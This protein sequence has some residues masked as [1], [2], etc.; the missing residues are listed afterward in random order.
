M[1][2]F[3]YH[4]PVNLISIKTNKN[5]KYKMKL[6]SFTKRALPLLFQCP[7]VKRKNCSLLSQLFLANAFSLLLHVIAANA[8]IP[9][10]SSASG[11]MALEQCSPN[12]FV[13]AAVANLPIDNSTTTPNEVL[14]LFSHGQPGLL[15]LEGKWQ[16]A[17]QIANWLTS[18]NLLANKQHINIYACEFAQGQKG[19]DAV[20]YLESTLGVSVAASTNMTGRNGDWTLEVGQPIA[21][22]ALPNYEG[23]LQNLITNGSFS[24]SANSWLLSGASYIGWS[25]HDQ[26]MNLN[27]GNSNYN[28]YGQQTINTIVGNSY[29]ITFTAHNHKTESYGSDWNQSLVLTLGSYSETISLQAQGSNHGSV[30]YS[31]TFTATSTAT[32]IKFAHGGTNSVEHD[33]LIDDVS[34]PYVAPPTPP[35]NAGNVAPSLSSSV[36]SNTCPTTTVN[37]NSMVIGSTTNIRWFNNNTHTGTAYA[38]PTAAVGGTYYAFYYDA[39]NNCYSP[40]SL[41]L[42]VNTITCGVGPNPD[43]N[44]CAPVEYITNSN[45]ECRATPNVCPNFNNGATPTAHACGWSDA[46][47]YDPL[48]MTYDYDNGCIYNKPSPTWDNSAAITSGHSGSSWFGIANTS[49]PQYAQMLVNKLTDTLAVGTY[50]VKFWAGYL[51]I[52]TAPPGSSVYTAPWN[53]DSLTIYGFPLEG[54]AG[55]GD[56]GVIGYTPTIYGH[57]VGVSP[58]ISN[59]ISSGNQTWVEYS[60]TITTTYPINKIGFIHFRQYSYIYIDDVSL[61]GPDNKCCVSPDKKSAYCDYDGDGIV[62]IKDLD[63]D[64]DGI[65]DATE[66]ANT[67]YTAEET[68]SAG[69]TYATTLASVPTTE[70]NVGG[71]GT[72]PY[73]VFDG[74]EFGYMFA[75]NEAN[76]MGKQVL[77]WK[78]N[79]VLPLTGIKVYTN[80]PYSSSDG[81]AKLQGSSDGVTWVNLSAPTSMAAT[82][83][84]TDPLVRVFDILNTLQPNNAY[85]YYRIV[86]VTGTHIVSSSIYEVKPIINAA[87]FNPS[88]NP[89]TGNWDVYQYNIPSASHGSLVPFT[90][91]GATTVTSKVEQ[92]IASG[93]TFMYNGKP[94]SKVASNIA[95]SSSGGISVTVQAT[96]SPWTDYAL[97]DA[98][99]ITNG[100]STFVLDNSSPTGFTKSG[101]W[102]TVAAASAYNGSYE[103]VIQVGSNTATWTFSNLPAFTLCNTDGDGLANIFDLDSDGDGCADAAEGAANITTTTNSTLDGGNFGTTYTGTSTNPVTQN[104]GNTVGTAYNTLGVP[105]LA[106]TGQAVGTSQNGT[107]LDTNCNNLTIADITVNESAGTATVQICATNIS[108]TPIT[109]TYTTSNGTATAGS[110]YTATTGTATIAAGQTCTSIDVPITDDNLGEPTE[111]INI[112]LTNPN[113]ATVTDPTAV[114]SITDN[115]APTLSVTDVVVNENAGTATVQICASN[116]STVPMTVT[117]TTANGTATSGTDYTA[118]TATATIAIGQTCTVVTVPIIDDTNSESPETFT[119]NLTNPSGATITDATGVITINDNDALPVLTINNVAVNEN[120]GIATL[121][122]CS[123]IATT[124]PMTV[125]YTTGNASATSGS[126]YTPKSAT[127]TIPAGQTCVNVTVSLIDDFINEPTETFNVT[128]TNPTGATIGDDTGVVTILDNDLAATPSLT[129][130]DVTV[131]EGVNPTATLQIC[132]SSTSTSPMTVTYTTSNGSA[133]SGSDYTTTTGTATIPAGQTCVDVTVPILDNT[134]NEPT[135][136]FNVILSNPS[137]ATLNDPVGVVTINDNDSAATPT[138]SINDVTVTEGVNPTATLQICASSTSTSPMTVTYTTNNGSATSGSDYSA[139]TATATIPA[140]QTCVDVTVPI[141]DNTTNEPTETFNVILSNPSSATLNDPVGVVTINDNDSAATPTLSI[142]DVTVTEGVNPTATLQICAS[143][144]SSSPMTVVYTTSNGS[145]TSG[146]DYSATTATATI[147]A[148]QTCVNVTVPIL[149]NTTN[150]PTETFNVILSNPS[151]ATLN[152]PLGVVTINDNDAI[153]GVL[154]VGDKVFNDLNNNG[155]Q[156]A[157]EPGIQGVQINL[158]DAGGWV[159]YTV[160]D[161]NGNYTFTS[162]TNQW[163]VAGNYRVCFNPLWGLSNVS[164]KD[165]GGN[166][167]LDSDINGGSSPNCTDF[168]MLSGGNVDIDAGFNNGVVPTTPSLSVNDVTVNEGAGTATLQICASSTSSSPI[169]VVYTTSNGSATSGSD[170]SATT[171]TATIPAGQTCVNVTVPLINDTTPEGTETFNVILSNPSGATLNDPVGVVTIN[172]N[173]SA[174]TPTLSINDVT[175]TEGVNPTATLQICAS[176]TSTSPI[177]VTYTTSNGSA[178]SGSDYSA[179]TATA[180]IPTGQTCVNV[181]VPILDNTTNEPSETFNV[182]LSSPS[183]ATIGDGTGVVTINDNDAVAGVLSV[184]DKVFNDLNNNGIQDAGEPG[185]QGV[186]INLYDA[187]GWVGYTVSDPNGNYTFSSATNQWIVAGSYRVCFNP[188]WGLSNVSPKDQGG[189]DALDSDI[190]GGSSPNC[191]DFFMLSGANVDIDAGFN[192]GVVPTT[193]SLSVNDVTVNEGAGTATLQICASSTSTSP[194]TVVYTTSNGSATSGSD[195]SATNMTATI[196]AGQT[197]VNVTVP[198]INDTTPEGTETFN[199]T[200]SSPTGATINDGTGVVTI[201]DNDSAATPVLSINDVTVTEGVNPTAT[202]QICASSTS[203][204]PMTVVYTTSNGSAT[205]GS[206]YSATNM[207][208]TIPAGQTCVNVTVPILDNTTNEPSETFNV[209]LT[210][211]SGATIGDGT[212]VVTINDNDAVAGVLSVGDKVFNDLNNNGIQ[213]AGEP[214]I[215]GVQINLYDA[216]GWVGYTV[217]DANGNYTFTSATNQWIVAGSYRVCFNPLWGLSNVSPKDQGGNDALD[218]DINGG[219]S[220]N[221]TDFFMLSGANVDIDAGFNNGVVPTTPSLSVND[222]TVNE[223]AGTATLQ[224][225]ASSTSTSP[226][227]V[228]YTTSNGS[229]TSGSDYSATNMTATIPAGQTCVNVTVPIINDTTPEGTETF[230]VTLSSPTGAT[231]NDGTSVVTITDNDSAAT[232][233]VSINDVT[234]TEGVNPTATLQICASSTSTSPM[235]VVYTTSN[236]SATSGSDYSATTA[237]ATIPAGQTCVN[238]TVPILDNTTNEPSETFNVTLSNPS[239]ATIGDGTGVVTIN[240]NDAVAG[241][242]SV[243]DKVFNDLNNNGIQDAGEPGIQG[244]QINLYDAG[245]WVGYTVS[246]ANGNYTFTSATNQ[247]I[248]AGSYRVCFNPLWGLSNVSPKDQGGNDALDSDINGGSSPNC[249]DFFMLSGGN[250]DIDAGFNNGVVPTTPSLSVADVTVNEGAGTATLQICASSTSSS[251]ITVVYTTSNGSA[252]SGSDYSATNMTATIPAGQTCVNVTVPI[253]N[254]TTPEGTETFNVTLSSPTGATIND[255]TSVVTITDNDSAA[256]PVL[257]IN[258]VTVTEGVNPT[259]TL[260]ICASSTSSSPMTVV[261]TTSNGSATSG[262]DYSATTATA[263]IPA[264]QTCVNVT[265]PILDNTTNEPSETFNVTLSSPSGA[266]IGD[267]TGVVTINDNDATTGTCNNVTYAGSIGYYQANAGSYNPEPVVEA[268][269][270]TGGSG[271]LEYVWQMSTDN[272]SWTTIAGATGISYDPST[273]STTTYYRRGVRRSNCSEYLYTSSVMKQVDTNMTVNCNDVQGGAIGYNQS[274]CAGGDPAPIVSITEATTSQAAGVRYQWFKFVGPLAP[275]DPLFIGE[276]VWGADGPSYD[277]PQW[278]VWSRTWYRRCAGVNDYACNNVYPGETEWIMVDVV[279]NGKTDLSEALSPLQIAPVPANNYA[280][281]NFDV[282]DNE[283]LTIEVVD[284]SGRVVLQ[285][286]YA[287]TAGNN[288]T[289]L[290]ISQLLNGYYMVRVTND[291]VAQQAKLVIVR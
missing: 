19:L 259:A 26:M 263:T 187:G 286:Q 107:L 94:F 54:H 137:S 167:A 74:N 31:R 242:L 35:C 247:W 56:P 238:V 113:G 93:S 100:Q 289:E 115:D 55:W 30:T 146:S 291:R 112:T 88:S 209:T 245:G 268:S 155:I 150:E 3:K 241:V 95:P 275:A 159:G 253:I 231:I 237:T 21:S 284:L 182:T 37:L 214:G 123:S 240:D 89:R 260:Q 248:V 66:C 128:L 60:A 186:Q 10:H 270:A 102:T 272:W 228:V 136:T 141:L 246:D 174:A 200:L 75:S 99:L 73:F 14:Q 164:P 44:N 244:V 250:V 22:I 199:V 235:T 205:S 80:G 192:N 171:A 39:A 207:T 108:T 118:S 222:V 63:D 278:Q 18:N 196:P 144:T 9:Q 262:S 1:I 2:F 243:G 133:T 61:L 213:D 15:L 40:T 206:D 4:L 126:D 70:M 62:N 221:C 287:A 77:A 67:Y 160:S 127:A 201:T 13:D 269:P 194:I 33:I 178:T 180:T 170:Y 72:L 195:Y 185:I 236:G 45:M 283:T 105:T 203:S 114:I 69:L 153:A 273:I 29:T 46:Q 71:S 121:Q 36:I 124:S 130:N 281:L 7:V 208:A 23:N 181:T 135:E 38:T 154:S 258:D 11:Y 28:G 211:P 264:G 139:T 277:P 179:T 147:P 96:G 210:S 217:S 106:G 252:T 12:L 149:D 145:A 98:V 202:L 251:P 81:T 156:D 274:I 158:Y 190:N 191:T 285:Q 87:L 110:D 129:V 151:G 53:P 6:F 17:A 229:A 111:T 140:G 233:V 109:V 198:I 257:S 212:G 47:I 219:S 42:T 24:G 90:V 51:G 266:T 57:K 193:P 162:A 183:G 271:T 78:Y 143:S 239:G 177:T 223:G 122:I 172:D 68:S 97:A 79:A 59:M 134:T 92:Q 254:D 84:S 234:V 230:N 131:T 232:P 65:T 165:Q 216:G 226:I 148:G 220:P 52:G 41:P 132:A 188:L 184:G 34:V 8:T 227:T 290:D 103:R 82:N 5:Q 86:G 225:C 173:D 83:L 261:Y 163:I 256:T 120:A 43:T 189:N 166:D 288:S 218:S 91:V 267:G 49:S 25:N 104:L 27:E 265:V 276:I 224:I 169:T 125:V 76:W 152:D 64:N 279:C 204:S 101:S 117:Y 16:N 58:M 50:T 32:L 161:A 175:V 255:G 282:A 176:S 197:C 116:A 142:N 157:G 280:V 249:T 85:Q 20:A 215:Q 168:F 48:Y 138:L 119:V